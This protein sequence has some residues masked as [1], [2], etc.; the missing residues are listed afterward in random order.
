MPT[1]YRRVLDVMEEA[2]RDG[3]DEHATLERVMEA[4]RG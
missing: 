4:S 1:D 3:L 2:G